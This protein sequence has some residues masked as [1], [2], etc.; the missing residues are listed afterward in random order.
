MK[1]TP[2]A[3]SAPSLPATRA[4]VSYY[5]T[6]AYER[7]G[8]TYADRDKAFNRIPIIYL[9]DGRDALV[10]SG[11]HRCT[12]ALLLGCPASARVIEGPWGAPR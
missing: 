6:G 3:C 5:L 8:T 4:G 9:R 7:T 2:R 1:S 12:A 11:H 10:L